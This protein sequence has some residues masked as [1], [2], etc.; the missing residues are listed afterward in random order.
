[1]L[2]QPLVQAIV[3]WFLSCHL[4][5]LMSQADNPLGVVIAERRLQPRG[6]RRPTVVVSLGKP[7]K[8]KGSEDW[9]CP[10]RITGS[11]IRRVEYGRGI[12]AFQALTMALEGI[13]YFLDRASTPLVWA[14]AGRPYRLSARHTSASRAGRYATDRAGRGSGGTPPT[15]GVAASAPST[16]EPARESAIRAA[17]RLTLEAPNRH[18]WLSM[19]LTAFS[20]PA[21]IGRSR[22]RRMRSASGDLVASGGVAASRRT[23]H[24]IK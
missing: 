10:F 22:V 18:R 23:R 4:G 13:R 11:G 5:G 1:M 9:E 19:S 2:G 24:R 16:S 7:R 8:T 12:D 15:E 21:L 20:S 14:G 17:R 3:R 6:V